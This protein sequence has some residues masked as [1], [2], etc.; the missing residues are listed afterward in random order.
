[1]ANGQQSQKTRAAKKKQL[2]QLE[3]SLNNLKSDCAKE[4]KRDLK[5]SKGKVTGRIAC[6]V[7]AIAAIVGVQNSS[8]LKDIFLKNSNQSIQSWQTQLNSEAE[9]YMEYHFID[10]GQADACLIL[11]NGQSML[12]DTGNADD[13][14]ILLDYLQD[15]GVNS[16]DYMVLT[17]PHEDHIG[18][19]AAILEEIPV[20]QIIMSPKKR[21]IAIYKNLE[22]I[23]KEKEILVIEPKLGEIYS[24]GTGN[25]QII[26][27][28]RAHV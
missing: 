21:E 7:I 23:I 11:S 17:H 8:Q 20:E 1:M 2:K 16:L 15:K 10:V 12:I 5:R 6:F 19:A 22:T 18:S 27:I 13:K 28:G 25:F 3:K 26:E 4:V 24:F 14:D 9:Y